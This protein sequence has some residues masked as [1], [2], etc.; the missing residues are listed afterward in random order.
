MLKKTDVLQLWFSTFR[1]CSAFVPKRNQ[2]RF[3][4]SKSEDVQWR[5][6]NRKLKDHRDH[7][8]TNVLQF[9]DI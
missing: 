3:E 7:T 4:A 5:I 6:L 9:L 1:T 8:D 2:S